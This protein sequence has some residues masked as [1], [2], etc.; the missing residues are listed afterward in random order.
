MNC[1]HCGRPI[2]P[3][4]WANGPGWSHQRPGEPHTT[5]VCWGTAPAE[6]HT[7]AAPSEPEDRAASRG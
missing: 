2:V 7:F 3:V 4:N 6:R 1:K 5:R